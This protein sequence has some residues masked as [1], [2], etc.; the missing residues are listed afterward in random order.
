MTSFFGVPRASVAWTGDVAIFVSSPGNERGYCGT[1]GS[2]MVFRS[3]RW[4]DETHL[5]ALS[6]DDLAQFKPEA[7]Y[8]YAERVPWLVIDDDLPKHGGSAD[9]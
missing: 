3:D 5:Y 7:H 4:P 8:H 2:Q 1:C 9:G 6:L